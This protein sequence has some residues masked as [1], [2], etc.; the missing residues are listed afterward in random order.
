[1]I[2]F[3]NGYAA[4]AAC[5]VAAMGCGSAQRNLASNSELSGG[6]WSLDVTSPA[7]RDGQA[8]PPKYAAA[9]GNVSPPLRWTSG[10]SGTTGYVIMV[11]DADSGRKMPAMHWLV[12]HLPVGTNELPENASATGNLTQGKNYKG[13]VGYAGPDPPKGRTH[14]YH[15]QVFA[16]DQTANIGPGATRA[17]LEKV[18][19]RGAIAKGEL[20]GTYKR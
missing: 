4:M 14:H 3:P 12:Y 20:I 19:V 17:D 9:G 18:A 13:E 1:M 8:I 16:V 5:L 15:F 2:R 11:E 6:L 10:P 7:F